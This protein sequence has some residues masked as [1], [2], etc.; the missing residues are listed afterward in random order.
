MFDLL[1][2]LLR[3][4]HVRAPPC[5]KDVKLNSNPLPALARRRELWP[6]HPTHA[7]TIEAGKQSLVSSCVR[8][9]KQREL[10]HEEHQYSKACCVSNNC[11]G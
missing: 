10:Q 7:R 6:M 9:V 11:I 8:F 2:I 5:T 1:A 3:T 4:G